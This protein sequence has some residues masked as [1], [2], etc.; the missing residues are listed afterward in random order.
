MSLLQR[1]SHDTLAAQLAQNLTKWYV[2][3]RRNYA[4][5]RRFEYFVKPQDEPAFRR[6]AEFLI[7][8]QIEDYYEFLRYQFDIR[9]K[10]A[11]PPMPKQCYGPRALANWQAREQNTAKR[12]EQAQ[13]KLNFYKT[14]FRQ[15]FGRLCRAVPDAESQREQLERS[16]LLD[17]GN[18]LSPLFRYC[19]AASQRWL[20]AV[21]QLHD[22]ALLQYMT[23]RKIYDQAWGNF[24]PN[25][26]RLE[27]DILSK[28][29]IV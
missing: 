14:H 1:R 9:G 12:V 2:D 3:L 19:A 11:M 8:N 16:V 10:A 27:A 18:Q 28:P 22:A 15:C 5:G 13:A 24:V 21:A 6:M 26:L 7:E 29:T 23:D 20:D 25:S 4:A 17:A